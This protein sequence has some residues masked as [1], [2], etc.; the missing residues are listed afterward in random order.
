MSSAVVVIDTLSVHFTDIFFFLLQVR[1]LL[2]KT[3]NMTLTPR[4]VLL[5]K[6]KNMTLTPWH[7][8][9]ATTVTSVIN[10]S[11]GDK[12][13]KDTCEYIQERNHTCA[14]NVGKNL[15]ISRHSR[16]ISSSMAI[17][18]IILVIFVGKVIQRSVTLENIGVHIIMKQ[19]SKLEQ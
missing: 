15:V 12:I 2:W 16:N 10:T 7:L 1:L 14:R 19:L 18:Y 6:T 11:T 8:A 17:E 4:Q 3:K 13:L 5:W 9:D